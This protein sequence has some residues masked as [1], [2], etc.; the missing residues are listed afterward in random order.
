MICSAARREHSPCSLITFWILSS[1]IIIL[2]VR[3]PAL[4]TGCPVA[5]VIGSSLPSAP[6]NSAAPLYLFRIANTASLTKHEGGSNA[7]REN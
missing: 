4:K 7:L 2:L 5:W 6:Q 3:L 1:A